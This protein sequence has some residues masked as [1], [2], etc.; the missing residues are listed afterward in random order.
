MRISEEAE[1][2][3]NN[4]YQAYGSETGWIFS[5][6]PSLHTAI[7]IIV[8]LTLDAH[9][10]RMNKMEPKTVGEERTEELQRN[11]G[12]GK[13][14]D[15]GGLIYRDETKACERCYK[16]MKAHI[17]TL[18]RGLDEIN[19]ILEGSTIY[20][21]ACKNDRRYETGSGG[22]PDSCGIHATAAIGY[23]SIGEIDI[24][25][26]VG[27]LALFSFYLGFDVITQEV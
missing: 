11:V 19:N 27:I 5:I 18:N 13:C 24:T 12:V 9:R 20:W 26:I 25:G 17:D 22:V 6:P 16:K 4:I 7:I 10:R 15:C 8:Q 14:A 1:E 3:T 2:I 21:R 23:F